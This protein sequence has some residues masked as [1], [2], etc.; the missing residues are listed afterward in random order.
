MRMNHESILF[1]KG[2]WCTIIHV[3][4]HSDEIFIRG[5][6]TRV[7]NRPS[8]SNAKVR[9]LGESAHEGGASLRT[10]KIFRSKRDVQCHA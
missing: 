6:S 7:E 10:V 1:C 3:S 2:S 5:Q 4:I 8:V 9:G